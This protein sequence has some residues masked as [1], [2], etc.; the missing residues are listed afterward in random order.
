MYDEITTTEDAGVR[1]GLLRRLL[2][3]RPGLQFAFI[4][5]A[6]PV[7]RATLATD[8]RAIGAVS[9]GLGKRARWFLDSASAETYSQSMHMPSYDTE[10]K[11]VADELA[12]RLTLQDTRPAAVS[13]IAELYAKTRTLAATAE[14][15]SIGSRTLDR[16][17]AK[18]PELRAAIDAVRESWGAS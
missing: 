6:Y 16:F 3:L 7:S 17:I 1:R 18:C 8:L 5:A 9:R 13:Q 2:R 4:A 15:L 12:M 10:T 11:S 14:A